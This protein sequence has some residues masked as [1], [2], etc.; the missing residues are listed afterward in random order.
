MKIVAI[1]ML[2]GGTGKTT[3]AV[4]LTHYLAGMGH[5]TLL[6]DVDKQANASKS[7]VST[8][9]P[10]GTSQLYVKGGA[11]KVQ[12]QPA[13]D[14]E[15][16]HV[17]GAD[18]GLKAVKEEQIPLFVDNLRAVAQRE[19]FD[20]VVLDTPP[21]PHD[22][23]AA[24]LDVTDFVFAP[25]VPDVYGL[26]NAHDL[27]ERI[28]EARLRRGDALTFLGFVPTRYNPRIKGHR[29]VLSAMQEAFFDELS[30]I[31]VNERAAYVNA[32]FEGK[33]VWEALDGMRSLGG[34]ARVAAKEMRG[35]LGW[36][37][38]KMESSNG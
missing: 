21:T 22:D 11:R 3:F 20:Y 25:I 10:H 32:S 2:K 37:Y 28:Q 7:F 33:P 5:K 14:V 27:N 23:M 12:V 17:I 19:G 36:L 9:S 16:V 31:A 35:A 4:H 30:P 13:D 1:C 26:D 18:P 8:V 34:A 24:P 15:N 38:E 29:E 6:V